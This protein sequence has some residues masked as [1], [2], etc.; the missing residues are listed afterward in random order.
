MTRSK[1]IDY[2][3][4]ITNEHRT[5]SLDFATEREVVSVFC[6]WLDHALVATD[7]PYYKGGTVTAQH[8]DEIILQYTIKPE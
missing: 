1:Q 8:V 7:S 6:E 4:T 5:D 3:V 2:T